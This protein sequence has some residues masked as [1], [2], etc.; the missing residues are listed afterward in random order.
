[1]KSANVFFTALAFMIFTSVYSQQAYRGDIC[2]N[3]PDLTIQQQQKI[4]KLGSAHQKKMDELRLQFHSESNVQKAAALKTQM[5]NE[6]QN[7][8]QKVT[9][10]LTPEQKTWYDQ[11]CN[12]YRNSH[13]NARDGYGPRCG[14][15]AGSGAGYGRGRGYGRGQGPGC[16]AG[17]GRGRGRCFY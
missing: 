8:Y 1:M 5:N 11:T 14:Y 15:G 10:L 7:H 2:R 3:I 6:M 4:D 12:A 17:Y 9:A 13:Y 16:G